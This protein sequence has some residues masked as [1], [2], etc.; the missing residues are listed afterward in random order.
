MRNFVGLEIGIFFIF[1]KDKLTFNLRASI[2]I[3]LLLSYFSV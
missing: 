1:S 3:L 2:S